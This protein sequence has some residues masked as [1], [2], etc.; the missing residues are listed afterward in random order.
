M[1]PLIVA[2]VH[3]AFHKDPDDD[4]ASSFEFGL[5]RQ[6]IYFR[7]LISARRLKK[8]E[9][10]EARIAHEKF[11]IRVQHWILLP[12]SSVHLPSLGITGANVCQHITAY[13]L[14]KD[15]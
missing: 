1:L 7:A 6:L 10:V 15:R 13:A 8:Y 9:T 4:E 2:D 11:L 12:A 3:M 14:L 5:R